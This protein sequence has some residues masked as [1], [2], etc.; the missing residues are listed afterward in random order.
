VLFDSEPSGWAEDPDNTNPFNHAQY[1]LYDVYVSGSRK[2]RKD[3]PVQDYDLVLPP[4]PIRRLPTREH[5]AAVIS[6]DYSGEHC[7][8]G[9]RIPLVEMFEEVYLHGGMKLMKACWL[10]S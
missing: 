10:K 6:R 8:F 9:W 5:L 3:Y 4:E 2:Q 7:I 1:Q